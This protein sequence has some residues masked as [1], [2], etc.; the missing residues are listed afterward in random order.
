MIAASAQRS[1][2][3]AA[4]AWARLSARDRGSDSL[5]LQRLF[6]TQR[7]SP[8]KRHSQSFEQGPPIDRCTGQ[9]QARAAELAGERPSVITISHQSVSSEIHQISLV[10]RDGELLPALDDIVTF[11]LE[12]LPVGRDAAGILLV[13]DSRRI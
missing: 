13:E 5:A 6:V 9:N 3:L 12:F 7:G 10:I 1:T 11:G 2:R 4:L 8:A